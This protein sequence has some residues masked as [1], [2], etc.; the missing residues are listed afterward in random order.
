V[1]QTKSLTAK[2]YQKVDTHV[3]HIHA[4]LVED[5]KVNQLVA[6]SVLNE[7]G[8]QADSAN[9]GLE[10]ISVLNNTAGSNP[11]DIIIM[12]CQMPN[13]DGYEA[14]EAI[15]S[16]A[17][18]EVY[19]DIP[20]IAMT[21]AT[22][23]EDKDKCLACGMNDFLSKPLD[24]EQLYDR[25][26]QWVIAKPLQNKQNNDCVSNTSSDATPQNSLETA[27]V[28]DWD[29]N[30]ILKRL[31]GKHKRVLALVELFLDDMPERFNDLEQ[32][33][34]ADDFENIGLIAHTIKG[35][36]AN[37]SAL[38][39][40]QLSITME[41]AAKTG[42]INDVKQQLKLLKQAHNQLIQV[43]VGYQTENK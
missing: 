16:G 7:L 8:I 9:D 25:L 23:P 21:A 10:A 24:A 36:S 40:Q 11:Y 37:L 3:T 22:M 19:K 41:K 5:N 33:V 31:K 43:L 38:Y 4:L 39:L 32:A 13:M 20:I 35:I 17:A 6:K 42:N 12:D 2:N 1:L 26:C 34:N 18:G 30:A 27:V 15:R 29:K 14:T 28:S